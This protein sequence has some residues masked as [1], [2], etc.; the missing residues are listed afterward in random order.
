LLLSQNADD[1]RSADRIAALRSLAA[2]AAALL[3]ACALNAA[4]APFVVRLGGERVV[5]DSPPGF[6]DSL[7]LSSPR[8]QELA[9][10]Q[11]SASNRV[12]LF[13]LS[14]ADLRRFMSGDPPDLKRYMV[15]VIPARLERERL[16]AAEFDALAAEALRDMG[17]PPAD[18]KFLPYLDQQPRGRARLLAELRRDP[19]ALSVLQGAR[20]PPANDDDRDRKPQYLFSTTTLLLLRGKVL[21]LSVYAMYDHPEDLDWLRTVT[22]RWTEDLQRLNRNP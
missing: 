9:E 1:T 14:D 16:S 3:A 12:L 6:S 19:L 13:A 7:G 4:A 20:L 15:V 22:H 18:V 21:T 11:T 10:S 8:L 2:L 5:L 17:P